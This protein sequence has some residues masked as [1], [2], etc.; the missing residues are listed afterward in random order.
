MFRLRT[1]K[2]APVPTFASSLSDGSWIGQMQGKSNAE[3]KVADSVTARVIDYQSSDGIDV[4]ASY[5]LIT[6]IL[7]PETADA[8]A[9]AEVYML[10]WEI[11][12]AFDELKTHQRG[13]RVVLRS[14]RPSLVYQELYGQLHLHLAIRHLM[15]D[16]AAYQQGDPRRLGFAAP[17]RITHNTLEHPEHFPPRS[18]VADSGTAPGWVQFVRRSAGQNQSDPATTTQPSG[19]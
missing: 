9:L 1:D 10:R 16:V 12:L 8:T 15:A 17:L 19:G 5:R 11:E 4:V 2:T 18:P 6:T 7:D 13:A 3:R 14:Q